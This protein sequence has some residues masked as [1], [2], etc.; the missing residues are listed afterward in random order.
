MQVLKHLN[1]D[2]NNLKTV[3]LAAQKDLNMRYG[4]KI[5]SKIVENTQTGTNIA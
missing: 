5:L 1:L 3:A 4:R 2:D